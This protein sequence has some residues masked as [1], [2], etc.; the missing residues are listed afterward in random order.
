MLNSILELRTRAQELLQTDRVMKDAYKKN[1]DLIPEVETQRRQKYFSDITEKS[2]HDFDMLKFELGLKSDKIKSAINKA[3]YPLENS[4]V[5]DA[6]QI[7]SVKS[8]AQ[9]L[10][11]SKLDHNILNYLDK[12]FEKNETDWLNY[13]Q[14][15][16]KLNTDISNE[17]RLEIYNRYSGYEKQAGITALN[18]QMKLTDAVSNQIDSYEKIV[19]DDNPNNKLMLIYENQAIQDLTN[20]INTLQTN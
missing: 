19:Q 10:A 2:K 18:L 3:K 14:D 17:L 13:F 20:E 7:E 16:V 4:A 11:L 12:S 8:R 9:Q 6:L 5:P 1:T 15:A